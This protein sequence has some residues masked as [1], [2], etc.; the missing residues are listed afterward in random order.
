MYKGILVLLLR[1]VMVGDFRVILAYS[2]AVK[3]SPGVPGRD[4]RS[5]HTPC[6][7]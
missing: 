7:T 6:Q 3:N 1:V 4:A 2:R 5:S